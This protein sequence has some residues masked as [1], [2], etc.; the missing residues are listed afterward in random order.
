MTEENIEEN[1]KNGERRYPMR[2]EFIRMVDAFGREE[3]ISNDCQAKD[4][5]RL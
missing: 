4:R 2:N 5:T 1:D 3:S